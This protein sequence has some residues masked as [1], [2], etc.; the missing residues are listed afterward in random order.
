MTVTGCSKKEEAEAN[1]YLERI[2]DGLS[3]GLAAFLQEEKKKIMALD[4]SE[5]GKAGLLKLAGTTV[6]IVEGYILSFLTLENLLGE[7]S[8]Y[9][10]ATVD[11]PELKKLSAEDMAE[12]SRYCA[13]LP[14]RVAEALEK[15][16]SKYERIVNNLEKKMKKKVV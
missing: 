11:I 16:L 1:R 10:K 5:Q 4:I 7:F 6:G 13:S 2:K 12:V 3:N 14:V 9:P 8:S 15:T